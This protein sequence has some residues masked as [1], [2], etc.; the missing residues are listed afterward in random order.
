MHI[1]WELVR[2]DLR[3]F[4]ADRRS[5]M[6][7]FLTPVLL[8]CFVGYL[9]GIGGKSDGPKKVNVAY[10]DEDR[11]EFTKEL[12]A[13]MKASGSFDVEELSE[14]KA[15]AKVDKGD[16]ALAIIV[17]KGFAAHAAQ[18]MLEHT[19][20]P[21][22]RLLT[23]PSR[24]IE[25]SL[26]KGALIRTTMQVLTRQVL[27]SVAASDDNQLPFHIAEESQAVQ[28]SNNSSP[29]AHAFAGMS[30]QGLLFWAIE[31]AMTLL[32]ERRMGI[33][34][35]LR[36][37]PVSPT[38]FLLGK[39]ISSAIRAMAILAFVFGTGFLVFKFQITP[40]FE[41]YLGFG[42]VAIAAS[43]MAAS[44]GLFV[45]ALGKNEQQSRGLSILAVL[46]MCMLGGAWFR[47]FL[48]PDFIQTI[49][50]AIPISW[51]VNGFDGMIWRGL[52][53]ADALQ[54][55]GVLLIFTL[56]FGGIALR[57]IRWEPEAA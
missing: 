24:T 9:F 41:N 44:F 10:V 37:T 42:L 19:S 7:S 16:L 35:R 20:A 17:P 34:R 30:M 25:A 38:M 15:K 26:S 1:L 5:V 22:F 55:V 11:N 33:W 21:E 56:I 13:K 47:M 54:S 14:A 52:G 46:G 2:K 57:R 28:S 6:I 48:M 36:S 50:K 8:A 53:L 43:L 29:A 45:A 49:S 39:G 51:A 12:L 31:S 4:L 40:K 32:R 23:D 27:G 3:I 18:S